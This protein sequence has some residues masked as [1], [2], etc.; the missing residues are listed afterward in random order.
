MR[1]VKRTSAGRDGG[2][3]LCK[4]GSSM[5]VW[6]RLELELVT[7]LGPFKVKERVVV[8]VGHINTVRWM[9]WTPPT[10]VVWCT[11][12]V[13]RCVHM[14]PTLRLLP[15]SW[16]ENY[17]EINAE[18]RKRFRAQKRGKK[19]AQAPPSHL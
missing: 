16:I 12:L 10:H 2:I 19:W 14:T 8:V 17:S 7:D 15:F 11:F 13:V 1:D 9:Q 6:L 4:P 18:K 5:H 3:W